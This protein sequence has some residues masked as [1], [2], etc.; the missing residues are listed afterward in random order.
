MNKNLR[1]Y[2]KVYNLMSP[3]FCSNTVEQLKQSNFIEHV[4]YNTKEQKKITLPN[5]AHTYY[6]TIA[7]TPDLM[8]HVYSALSQYILTDLNFKWFDGWEGYSV[9]RFNRYTKGQSL[10][11]HCDQIRNLVEGFQKGVPK[12]TTLGVLNDDYSG[13][14][15]L[16]FEDEVIETKVGDIIVFPSS[17]LYPHL[18]KEVT[19]GERYT[20]VSWAW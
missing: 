15:F 5:Q 20:F 13:G 3:E 11:N 4:V 1:D 17:F 6:G 2:V 10:H 14:E 16:M 8:K 12:I 18:V 7:N 9:P 19:D